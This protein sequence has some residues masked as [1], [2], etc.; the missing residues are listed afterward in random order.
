MHAVTFEGKYLIIDPHTMKPL[1]GERQ[2]LIETFGLTERLSPVG[3]AKLWDIGLVELTPNNLDGMIA[4]EEKPK[5]FGIFIGVPMKEEW[6]KL[7]H[8][9]IV[10][11]ILNYA[12]EKSNNTV[13]GYTNMPDNILSEGLV[14]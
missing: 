7:N 6:K 10:N 12:D 11:Q 13:N 3:M 1:Q 14:I 2:R 9:N 5:I 8:E 4:H